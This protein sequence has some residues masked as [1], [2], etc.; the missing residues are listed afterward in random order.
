VRKPTQKS[1]GGAILADFSPPCLSQSPVY[2]LKSAAL[3]LVRIESPKGV[4]HPLGPSRRS[5]RLRW[6]WRL[7]ARHGHEFHKTNRYR[8]KSTNCAI[9]HAIIHGANQIMR[10]RDTN[11]SESGSCSWRVSHTQLSLELCIEPHNRLADFILFLHTRR[12]GF[13]SMQ[14]RSMIPSPKGFSNFMQGGFGVAPSQIH[15]HLARECNIRGAPLTSHI[16]D[17]N[18]KMF[19]HLL[20]NLINSGLFLASSRKISRR[21][22]SSVSREISRPL[23]ER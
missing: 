1:R 13:A 10:H 9:G 2:R 16:R 18:I 4:N 14:H 20:L 21:N 12:D 7:R 22:C 15:R 3:E 17:L 5:R 8:E 6:Q 19:G 11:A 23:S